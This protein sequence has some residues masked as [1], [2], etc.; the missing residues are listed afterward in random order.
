MSH[1]APRS[2]WVAITILATFMVSLL[3]VRSY[4]KDLPP[5]DLPP[6]ALMVAVEGDI[7]RPGSYLMEGPEVRLSQVIEAAGGLLHGISKEGLGDSALVKIRSGQ[8]VRVAC[9]GQG[10]VEIRVEAMPAA[11]RLTLGEKL[12]LNTASGED[13]MLVP[14]MKAGFVAAIIYR[15]SKQKWQQ[16]GELEEISG[17]GP[18]TVEKWRS[19]LEANE[20]SAGGEHGTKR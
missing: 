4:R 8:L 11:A 13:L 5:S 20:N 3:L 19:Y 10:A 9:S 6:I 7:E 15:R 12:D 17:I 2:Q 1:L 16:L 14:Q 18:K